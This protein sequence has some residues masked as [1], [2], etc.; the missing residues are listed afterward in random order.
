MNERISVGVGAAKVGYRA[1]PRGVWMLGFVSMFMDISSEMIHA[2]LPVFLVTTLGASAELVGLIEGVAEATTAI[3]KIFS[4]TVSDW[5]GKRKALAVAGYGMGALSK[6]FF[7]IAGSPLVVF[8]ARFVDRVG[9]GVRGAP[10]D[11]L[12]ADITPP[13]VRGAAY[14]VRQAIDTVGAFTGPLIAMGLLAFFTSNVRTV[15]WIAV[16][17]G[18]IA[19]LLLML[20]VE[21]PE[22]RAGSGSKAP[23]LNA[24]SLR[25]LDVGFWTVV[26][27]GIVFMF[28][29]FSE[30]F[31]VL[32][33]QQV[34]LSL[35]L[36]PA[37]LIVMN[38]VYALSATPAGSLSDRMD[39]RYVLAASLAVLIAA[40]MVLALWGSIAG[41]MVGVA[42]W[43][44]HMGLSQGLLAALVADA[45]PEDLRGTA[46]GV[47]NLA[48]GIALLGASVL[49]GLLWEVAGSAS[50]FLAGAGFS[51]LAL[52]S[53]LWLV[54]GH[55]R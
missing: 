24:A 22:R 39:R 21:E 55:S 41:V 15:F 51:A 29:R 20:G 3:T 18:A 28:A 26:G 47:F 40:D 54:R 8:G 2:L 38:I 44:L 34:G 19:V 49:A 1:V 36:I 48:S 10:R 50:T 9:K 12:V 33:G 4:G 6:P 23:R 17:P 52:V 14:G 46:F 7:A 37:V 5:L 11:A 25:A 13:A 45:A 32:R 27:I 42:L 16:I 31:L 43:G 35:A 53:V 30:A